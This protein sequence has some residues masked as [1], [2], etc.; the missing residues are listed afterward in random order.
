MLVI[1]T[2]LSTL[3]IVSLLLFF[4]TLLNPPIIMSAPI[5]YAPSNKLNFDGDE[6]KYELWEIKFLA[7]LRLQKNLVEVVES[8]DVTGIADYVEKNSRIFAHIVQFL[9]DTSLNLI[10]RDAKNDG[11][12][13]LEIL[14]EHYLG[15]SKPRIIALY[16]ELCSMKIGESESVTDYLIRAETAA[17]SLKTAKEAVSDSL[18]IAMVI[19]GLPD[20]YKAFTTVITQNKDEPKFSDF[21]KSLRSYE[22]SE[23]CRSSNAMS[24]DNVMAV[25][26]KSIMNRP[27]INEVLKC[28]ACSGIGH[29]KSQ[30]PTFSNKKSRWC[31]NCK[32]KTHDTNWCRSK[33]SAKAVKSE[34]SEKSFVFKV[35]ID[36]EQMHDPI[37]TKCNLL[38]DTGASSHI[39]ND[40]SKFVD[41]DKN[42]NSSKHYIELADGSRKNN[43]VSA[44]GNAMVKVPDCEGTLQDV[45]LKNALCIPS[46]SQNIFSVQAATSQ[47]SK[48]KFYPDAAELIANNGK[49][50]DIVKSGKL[51]YLDKVNAVKNK[52]VQTF[53]L[54]EWHKVLG[55]CNKKDVLKLEQNVTG[56]KIS[57]AED[58]ECNVCPLGKMTQTFSH[59]PDK[60]AN[61]PLELVYCDLTGPITPHALNHS[62]YVIV[63]V[64]DF[65]NLITVYFLKNKNDA[66]AATERFLADMAPWGTVK[67][68][69]TDNGGEFKNHSFESLLV[70]NKI[71]HEFTCSYSSFQNGGA[72]R[73]FRSLFDMARCLLIESNLPKNLW[74]YAVRMS[75]YLRNRCISSRTQKTPFENFTGSKPDFSK[76]HGF[77]STCFSYEH[78]KTKLDN[79]SKQGIFIGYDVNSPALLVYFPEKRVVTRSRCVVFHDRSFSDPDIKLPHIDVNEDTPL[80]YVDSN[81]EETSHDASSQNVP[82]GRVMTPVENVPNGGV[83]TPVEAH[84]G[85]PLR[86]SRP[87]RI[88]KKPD[89]LDQYV[90]DNFDHIGFCDLD[91]CYFI[92]N[93]PNSYGQA[94]ASIDSDKWKTAMM[95]EMSA[96]EEN[97]T[98]EVSSLPEN[99]KVIG[100]RWVFAVKLGPNNEEKFKARYV[101]K[102][103]SQ[104]ENIDYEETFSPTAKITSI[105][106]LVQVSVQN[107][108][109]LHQMDFKTAYLNADIDR[110]IYVE[111]PP[112][113]VQGNGNK[114]LRLNKSLYGLKQSGRNWNNVLHQFLTSQG[115]IQ[116]LSDYCLYV[117]I[118]NGSKIIVLIWV[119]DL[120]IAASS[121]ELLD[122]LKVSL[123]Q[124]FKMKDLGKLS[125]FLGI[126]FT[127]SDSKVFMSQ[128]NYLTRVLERFNML[129]CNPKSLPCDASVLSETTSSSTLLED[130]KLYRQIVGSL[131]YAMSCTRPDLC[132]VVGKLSQKL[133]K[134]TN[135]DLSLA[136]LVLR[137]IKGT[138]NYGLT[139]SKSR[140]DLKITGY[141]D[142]DYANSSDRKSISGYCFA[143]SETGPIISWK[144]KKQQVIALSSCESE[145]ISLAY[146]TQEAVFLRQL[147]SDLTNSDTT[148]VTIN[149]DNQ[150][151]IMLAKNPVFHQRSKHIDVKYHYIRSQIENGTIVLLY[152]PTAENVADVFTKPA[153]KCSLH[154][155]INHLNGSK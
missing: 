16:T 111:Q 115:Y 13:S 103:Y 2:L 112:G 145:Y 67:S 79:R 5:G 110:E 68:I 102:G 58:F 144:S 113:F 61:A 70:K 60:E 82:N 134:P 49:R 56:M 31:E 155:F 62:C 122:T 36:D 42:F 27:G 84:G 1:I 91:Y 75:A 24:N 12:R 139:F 51:Y 140:A 85:E 99:R 151:A 117:K 136:K 52:N 47:G 45:L 34:S 132:Y 80:V 19:K 119:D 88:R 43:I 135:A 63:F 98:F 90:T 18:L 94:V 130:D 38:V 40:Q 138:L 69:R 127:V 101:A 44:R 114:V 57:D 21:K 22:E 81:D 125:H 87:K 89:Y 154:K 74:N 124:S 147:Y 32:S 128:E 146:A 109:I 120:I 143:L 30:C 100:G 77:G 71:K 39:L 73:S 26:S 33:N 126:N 152:V 95:E 142:A 104:V 66:C 11:R 148:S 14:R 50:F 141:C 41:L 108:Y 6:G 93:V 96:L 83:M 8:S 116:S 15:S 20:S 29:R 10:I 9:D 107:G 150:G 121:H 97:N 105:R 55:H 37:F 149:C 35:N 17:T 78:K 131:I 76:L 23:K 72:E 28:F 106:M 64:D 92:K 137:Y 3:P 59:K 86:E 153:N 53:S 4:S 129:D 123:A 65:S 48:V 133:S 118:C 54:R 7:F 46:F 25:K